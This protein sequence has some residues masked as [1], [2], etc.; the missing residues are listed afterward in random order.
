MSKNSDLEEKLKNSKER[1]AKSLV[2]ILLENCDRDQLQSICEYIMVDFY[3]SMTF[4]DLEK[5]YHRAQKRA[6]HERHKAKEK[7]DW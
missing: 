4:V 3:K 1:M 2:A 7:I 6:L 5:E